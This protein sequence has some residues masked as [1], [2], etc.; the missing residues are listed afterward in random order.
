MQPAGL[1]ES[2][3]L[4][5]DS[6]QAHIDFF[7]LFHFNNLHPISPQHRLLCLQTTK[8]Q[9]ISLC[10]LLLFQSGLLLSSLTSQPSICT[11]TR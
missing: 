5:V 9:P 6:H 1:P 3:M 10:T 7:L 4:S 11:T 2:H 8:Q